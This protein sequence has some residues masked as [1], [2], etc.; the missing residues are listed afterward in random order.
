MVGSSLAKPFNFIRMN[1]YVKSRYSSAELDWRPAGNSVLSAARLFGAGALIV[2]L[3]E[4]PKC[5]LGERRTFNSPPS[6]AVRMR[7]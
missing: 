1:D 3:G 2:W 5:Y 6:A 7:L 4:I